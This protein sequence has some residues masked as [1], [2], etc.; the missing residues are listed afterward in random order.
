MDLIVQK[1]DILRRKLCV[2][3]AFL[4]SPFLHLLIRFSSLSSRPPY[5]WMRANPIKNYR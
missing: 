5:H 4:P 1:T 3:L 2:I